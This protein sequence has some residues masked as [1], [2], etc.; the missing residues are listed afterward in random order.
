MAEPKLEIEKR[1]DR[2]EAAV[3][4]TA[5]ILGHFGALGTEEVEKILRGEN[6]REEEQSEDASQE[7]ETESLGVRNKG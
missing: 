6:P 3:R 7:S 5:E 1:V 4:K 2:V